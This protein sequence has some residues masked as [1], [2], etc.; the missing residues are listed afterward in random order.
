M[1]DLKN[2][3]LQSDAPVAMWGHNAYGEGVQVPIQ[4]L[5][6]MAY[7]A[8]SANYTVVAPDD[9]NKVIGVTTGT[10]TID[11]TLP[12]ATSAG[13]GA[14]VW[15]EKVDNVNGRV[16]VKSGSLVI[17]QLFFRG[18]LVGFRVNAAGT[19]WNVM[20]G[21]SRRPW[22][23][24]K[25]IYPWQGYV[26]YGLPSALTA[27]RLRAY[28]FRL[29]IPALIDA[30]QCYVGATTPS[31]WQM[32]VGIYDYNPANPDK[33]DGGALLATGTVVGNAGGT[34]SQGNITSTFTALEIGAEG[35]W[36]GTIMSIATNAANQ[37]YGGLNIGQGIE[38]VD[39]A[40]ETQ[41]FTA[42]QLKG[43]DGGA[44][45]FSG[46][47]PSTF[48]SSTHDLTGTPVG[49]VRIAA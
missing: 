29:G 45:T 37:I 18:H 4:S 32:R 23:A 44:A 48:P 1:V 7:L 9:L 38:M 41:G 2:T 22:V 16:H 40:A 34:T 14:V 30:V 25:L 42:S 36:I 5:G 24:G 27:D 12:T 20:G 13:A 39:S 19:G 21:P 17:K 43:F 35:C 3:D 6:A 11:I 10:G 28:P 15:I 46:G 47:L 26:A 33:P 49:V 31:T 8:K